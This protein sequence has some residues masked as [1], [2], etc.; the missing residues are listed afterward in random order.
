MMNAAGR[1]APD[2]DGG[3]RHT[4]P[5]V[6]GLLLLFLLVFGA[7]GL[8]IYFIPTIVGFVR[9]VPNRGALLAVNAF[10]GWT[11]IGWIAA[12]AMALRP[13]APGVSGPLEATV[14]SDV[15]VYETRELQAA[16]EELP[17]DPFG[18]V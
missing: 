3:T 13:P 8:G 5:I 4:L 15:P 6:S 14:V 18:T 10:L 11:F 1:V 9:G 12:M 16:A 7:I 2:R 17:E